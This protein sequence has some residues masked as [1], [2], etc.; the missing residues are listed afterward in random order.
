MQRP[1]D[2]RGRFK[3]FSGN[4][5]YKQC[6][7]KG[8]RKQLHHKIWEEHYG[9]ILKGMLIHH[10][11]LN[12]KDNR[13]ENLEL[14]DYNQHNKIHAHEAWN[15]GLPA[16]RQ[17]AY[18]RRYKFKEET[19]VKQKQTWNKKYLPLK[20]AVWERKEKGMAEKDIAKELN[21]AEHQV[22]SAWRSFK[23][24]YPDLGGRF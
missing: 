24:T 15:K 10:K 17:P 20:L 8:V 11:N 4:Q 3:T 16:E 12:K 5:T 1:K 2:I 21:V 9:E 18:G 13:L 7:V 22:V 14:M 19:K 6:Q 23:K